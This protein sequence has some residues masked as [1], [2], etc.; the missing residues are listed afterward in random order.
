MRIILLG[1]PGSGKGTQAK[2]ISEYFKVKRISLGDILREEVKN[3]SLLGNKVKQ[4]MEK[5][6]LV[7]DEIMEEIINENI[8]GEGFVLD[9]YPRNVKQAR[10]LDSILLRRRKK[11]DVVFYLDVDETTVLKRLEFRR[12]CKKCGANYHLINMPP[13]NEEVCDLCGEKLIQ[14]RDDTPSVIKERL[15]VFLNESK[16]LLHFYKEEDKLIKIDAR[17]N[18]DEVFKDIKLFLENGR[19]FK[20]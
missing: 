7:P 10:Y 2:E 1:A 13:K 5:G 15:N 11:I 17:R 9:G 14:R 6:I 12:I 8:T 3:N 18:K 4:Y 16:P 19:Y 20:Q